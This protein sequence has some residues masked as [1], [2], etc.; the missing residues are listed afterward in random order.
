MKLIRQAYQYTEIGDFQSAGNILESLIEIDP[1]D[2]E[3]WE[4]YMQICNTCD[5]LD[6]LCERVLQ[7]PDI[8][9]VDRKSLLDYY[10]FLWKKKESFRSCRAGQEKINFK[11]VDQ[12]AFA[13]K[14]EKPML[15]YADK[16]SFKRGLTFI[17]NGSMLVSYIILLIVSFSLLVN[18]NYF[19]YWIIAV[20]LIT[21]SLGGRNKL[22]L[23][24]TNL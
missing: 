10:F 1:L 3:A 12:I 24:K 8:N 6:I 16:L 17:L 21:V 18:N 15:E 20:L 7:V 22:F 19:G 9:S 4:A 11:V 14:N 5:E 23:S 13:K 2:V